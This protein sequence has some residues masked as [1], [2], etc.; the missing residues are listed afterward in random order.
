MIICYLKYCNL[1]NNPCN[2][3]EFFRGFMDAYERRNEILK[4]Q[5]NYADLFFDGQVGTI[6]YFTT[7]ELIVELNKICN[8]TDDTYHGHII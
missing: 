2:K 3:V 4:M 8:I 1:N 5:E 6:E 7:K